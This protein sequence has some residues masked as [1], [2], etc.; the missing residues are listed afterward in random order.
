MA[1]SV[2]RAGERFS[3]VIRLSAEGMAVE[4]V[5]AVPAAEPA[6]ELAAVF[7]VTVTEDVVLNPTEGPAVR[8]GTVVD[9]A[10]IAQLS[11]GSRN[12]GD[13]IR[14]ALPTLQA[15][16][17][18]GSVGDGLCLE[19]RG[20]AGRSL[21]P[22]RS[23]S[24]CNSPQIYLDGVALTD[25]AA[26]YTMTAFEGIQWIQAIPP[27][28]AGA[29]FGQSTY[30][31]I[32]IATTSGG[33]RM[34][35]PAGPG[36]MVRSRRSTFDW[37]QDPNGHDFLRTFLAAAAGNAAGLAA[38]LAAGRRCVYVEDGTR[39]IATRCSNAG[40]AGVGVAAFALPA[41]GS[42]LGAHFGGSTSVSV[43]RWVPALIGAGMAIFPGYAFSLTTVGGGVEATNNAG[44]AFLLVGT[45]LLTTLADR[46]Y[47]R[48]REP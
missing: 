46:L 3:V 31:V 44:K 43:G 19:F 12:V 18:D 15:R 38:G 2:R 22:G 24:T 39:E 33:T 13:L 45:P 16:T 30:G 36:L 9:K 6:P 42:A 8:A 37:E 21:G 1:V 34:G 28:E 41:M 11:G 25:P 26:A 5:G 35:A 10:R 23:S 4:I 48:L 27:G 40:V 14:R 20:T 17:S 7:P 32:L 29:Q 47:R